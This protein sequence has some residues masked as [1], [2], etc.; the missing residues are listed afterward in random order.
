[1]NNDF[2]RLLPMESRLSDRSPAV[3]VDLPRLRVGPGVE[4]ELCVDHLPLQGEQV[5]GS[6]EQ[7]VPG[8]GQ[9]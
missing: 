7:V 5:D 4:D 6:G 9:G 3:D 1:M 2:G 8:T